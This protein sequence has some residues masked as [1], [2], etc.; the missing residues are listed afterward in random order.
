[1]TLLEKSFLNK[2]E[3]AMVEQLSIHQVAEVDA[4]VA[5]VALGVLVAWT[6]LG[7]GQLVRKPSLDFHKC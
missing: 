3:T 4:L 7:V 5:V 2:P 1:M 6:Q